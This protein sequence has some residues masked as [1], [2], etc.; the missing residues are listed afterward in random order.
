MR[1][2]VRPY[3]NKP[4]KLKLGSSIAEWNAIAVSGDKT[5]IKDRVY[6]D[7]YRTQ[8]N[9]ASRVLDKLNTW[10]H[11]K[12]AYCE[13]I[14]KMDVEHYRPKGEVCDENNR[15]IKVPGLVAGAQVD[16]PGYYWLCYEWSNLLPS[17]ITCNRE[18]G[19]N[20]K[21]PTIHH[22]EHLPVFNPHPTLDYDSCLVNSNTLLTEQP[23][24]LNPEIDNPRQFFTFV[25]DP[26]NK[27]I[28]IKGTDAQNRGKI[29]AEICMLNRDD[30]R[31]D[32]V[33]AVI[34]PIQKTVLAHLKMLSL[35]RRNFD[36]FKLDLESLF[37]KLY[38]DAT[39][40]TLDHTLLRQFI[41]E[42][43]ANFNAIVI[44][45]I[46]KRAKKI[47]QVAFQNYTPI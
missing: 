40:E 12:C 37:Q 3:T 44:P 26:N 20:S 4:S 39:D 32:R 42:S 16:H 8:D 10:Y 43:P 15:P 34:I 28:R 23:Y 2:V 30:V 41:V 27:G 1:F 13:R 25:L 36:Q 11:Q 46:T 7:P 21:F 9:L 14:Y 19:K 5:L 38:W 47:L 6:R 29:T 24:I 17:C 22:Y 45:F 33:T 31:Y 35:G 18:G